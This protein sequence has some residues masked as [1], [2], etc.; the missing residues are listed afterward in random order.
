VLDLEDLAALLHVVVSDAP[1]QAPALLAKVDGLTLEE[2]AALEGALQGD[3][4]PTAVCRRLGDALRGL[5]APRP[6]VNECYRAAYW[7]GPE[8]EVDLDNPLFTRFAAK[9]GGKI[10]DKW[11]HYFRV[12]HRHLERFRGTSARVLE[13]GV[14]RG[15]GLEMLRGYL[16]PDAHLVGLDIDPVAVAVANGYVVVLGDQSD[17]EVLRAVS[18]EHGPFDVV[19][20]DG[21]HT[22]EQQIGAAEILLPLL[23]PGGVYLVEDTHTS[24]WAEYGG[25]LRQEGT[26]LEWA[27]DRVDDLH[28]FHWSTAAPPAPLTDLIDGMHVYDSIVVLDRADRAAPFAELAGT[29]DALR[30]TRQTQLVTSG[31]LASRDVARRDAAAKQ[32]E[33]D[34]AALERERLRE[35]RDRARAQLRALRASRSWRVMSPVRRLR[36]RPDGPS[37]P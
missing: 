8:P 9:R 14:F 35:Q 16:G 4:R 22:M 27:K 2:R 20:D 21:G 15:G 36:R 7:S 24:Y 13:I 10:V 19:I 30:L 1:E 28:A 6:L 23:K 17:P 26:F 5:E 31:L 12:Y 33:L 34:A 32:R 25:G 11:P 18:E 37:S 29:W 3:Q